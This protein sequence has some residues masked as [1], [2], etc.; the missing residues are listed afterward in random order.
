MDFKAFFYLF[1]ASSFLTQLSV[2]YFSL[3][4]FARYLLLIKLEYASWG[5]FWLNAFST[6][7]SQLKQ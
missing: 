2:L 7:L 4:V 5:Q 3:F 1:H 6:V